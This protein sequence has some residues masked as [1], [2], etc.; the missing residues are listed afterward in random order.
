ME[1]YQLENFIA[2]VEEHSFTRAAERVYRTQGAVSI[3]IRKLEDEVGVPLMVRD[4][5][6]CALTEAGQQLLAYARRII[7]LRDEIHRCMVEFRSLASG[8]VSIAAHE[9]A[10]QYLLPDPLA[11]FHLSHP[12]VKMVTRQCDG[13]DIAHLVA[14]REVDIGFGIRQANLHGLCSEAVHSDPLVLIAALCHPLSARRCVSL[15]DLRHE[16]FFVHSR[17]TTMRARVESLFND[18][19]VPFNVASE[20]WNFET[21]KQFVQTG[22]GIAIVPASVAR[23]D[24]ETGRLTRVPVDDLD[25]VR[26]IEVVYREKD[27]LLPAPAELLALLRQ[28]QWDRTP[29]HECA[30]AASPTG[31]PALVPHPGESNARRLLV[32]IDD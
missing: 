19:R 2:V 16:R 5:H 9:S 24:L 29:A 1:F 15:S 25:L 7:G 12:N 6:E 20:L 3:A 11:F 32:A 14:E 21:I 30:P 27:S 28:W 18:H 10:A 4:S 23:R 31:K 17:F 8:R 26:T 13:Q 22:G